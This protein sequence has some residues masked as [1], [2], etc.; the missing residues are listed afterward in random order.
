MQLKELSENDEITVEKCFKWHKS[1]PLET[2]TRALLLLSP[3][4]PIH[5]FL[6]F[7]L[8]LHSR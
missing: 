3:V 2:S 4:L 5:L 6:T 8:P 7:S 1:L